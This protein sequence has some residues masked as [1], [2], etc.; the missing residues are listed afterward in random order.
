MVDNHCMH[1]HEYTYPRPPLAHLRTPPPALFFCCR[2]S[3]VKRWQTAARKLLA[4][5]RKALA[6]AAA[7]AS[8]STFIVGGT[9]KSGGQ[10]RQTDTDD[11]GGVLRRRAEACVSEVEGELKVSG[12]P[13]AVELSGIVNVRRDRSGG[14]GT[15]G[16]RRGRARG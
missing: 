2:V 6:E 10:K 7:S 16:E 8:S 9:K 5:L 3:K 4:A 15:G 14:E 12:V 1:Y 11:K 13:E